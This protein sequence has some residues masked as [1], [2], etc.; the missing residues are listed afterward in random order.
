MTQVDFLTKPEIREAVAGLAE[1][2]RALAAQTHF[3]P[4]TGNLLDDDIGFNAADVGKSRDYLALVDAAGGET[5]LG[6]HLSWAKELRKYADTQLGNRAQVDDFI[7]RLER[8]AN[9]S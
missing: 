8:E 3:D 4:R 5:P 6:V 9:P 1:W 2:T 7:K